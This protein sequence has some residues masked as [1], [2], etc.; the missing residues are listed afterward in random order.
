MSRH[1][2]IPTDASYELDTNHAAWL[3][4]DNAQV[5]IVA[6]SRRRVVVEAGGTRH[7]LWRRRLERDGVDQTDGLTFTVSHYAFVAE[8]E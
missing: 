2:P 8:Q 1:H 3:Y 6:R 4:L 7:R 5:P